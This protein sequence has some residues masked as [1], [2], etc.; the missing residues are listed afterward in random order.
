MALGM[1]PAILY[2]RRNRD[3]PSGW[4]QTAGFRLQQRPETGR[5]P[6]INYTATVVDA[7]K[8]FWR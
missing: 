5:S 3:A 1:H 4:L 2:L 8:P 7:L 6:L